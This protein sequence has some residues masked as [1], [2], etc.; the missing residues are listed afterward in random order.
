VSRWT[1]PFFPT[2]GRRGEVC[3]GY[4][5][6]KAMAEDESNPMKIIAQAFSLFCLISCHSSSESNPFS[7]IILLPPS[8]TD[9]MI[10]PNYNIMCE[11]TENA[12]SILVAKPSIHYNLFGFDPSRCEHTPPS[13][14][15][16]SM[17]QSNFY[18]YH[19][20]YGKPVADTIQVN[21]TDLEAHFVYSTFESNTDPLFLISV[22]QSKGE[23]FLLRAFEL[24]HE[25]Q[26]NPSNTQIISK[27]TREL[28]REINDYFQNFTSLCPTY[29]VLSEENLEDLFF[30]QSNEICI[31]DANSDNNV[32]DIICNEH[33]TP[34]DIAFKET[35]CAE[36]PLYACC[37]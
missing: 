17:I 18:V 13:D 10:D 15:S 35:F 7:Q 37:F 12:S 31:P 16:R 36:N 11:M 5:R 22:V 3:L 34:E 21:L 26:T 27:D 24:Q 25:D 19:Q 20:L 4:L 28:E 2:H 32:T 30:I 1:S 6:G 29:K 14:Y 33:P 8:S 23:Y 9:G